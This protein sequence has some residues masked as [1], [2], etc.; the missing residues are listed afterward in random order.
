VVNW[1]LEHFTRL[2][3][4][5]TVRALIIMYFR[6][7]MCGEKLGHHTLLQ[8]LIT[9]DDLFN[10]STLHLTF[11]QKRART[12]ALGHKL[13]NKT[14]SFAQVFVLFVNQKKEQF[15]R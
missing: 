12:A 14:L 9:R 6:K 4:G 15:R 5:F 3:V 7:Q 13:Q 11:L 1:V 2:S 8:T 10:I